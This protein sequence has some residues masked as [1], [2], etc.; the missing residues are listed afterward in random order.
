MRS[1]LSAS[2]LRVPRGQGDRRGGAIDKPDVAEPIPSSL[3]VKR[4]GAERA[5]PHCEIY[6]KS[7]GNVLAAELDCKHSISQ[8]KRR[9]CTAPAT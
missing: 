4:W 7:P 8:P 9:A 5:T 2:A 1:A 3:Q 6:H